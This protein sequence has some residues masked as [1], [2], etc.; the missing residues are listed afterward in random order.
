VDLIA[1]AWLPR[2]ILRLE[3]EYPGIE[4]ELV[5]DSTFRL[6][7]LIREREI[8]LACLVGPGPGLDI[9]AQPIGSVQLEWMASPDLDIPLGS[10]DPNT[11][12]QL[13]IIS[14]SRGSLQYSLISE[15]FRAGKAG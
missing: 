12:A 7:D 4:V 5:I 11:L 6:R 9:A 10:L 14:D 3:R 15:W 2:L 13:P 1:L 8:D